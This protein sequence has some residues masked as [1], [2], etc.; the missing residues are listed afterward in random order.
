MNAVFNLCFQLFPIYLDYVQRGLDIHFLDLLT[1][2]SQLDQQVIKLLLIVV[3]NVLQH[4]S[5]TVFLVQFQV[6]VVGFGKGPQIF[7][8]FL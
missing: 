7:K 3:F 1:M 8:A 5:V 6:A 2:L 4:K